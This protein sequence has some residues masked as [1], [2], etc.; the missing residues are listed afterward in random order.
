MGV[1][2]IVLA[3]AQVIANVDGRSN[4]KP[5]SQIFSIRSTT[6]IQARA[7]PLMEGWFK[8][9]LR[10]S[11]HAFGLIVKKVEVK[12]L[13]VNNPIKQNTIFKIID[14]V[15]VTIHYLTHSE[16][17]AQTG[18]VFGIRYICIRI[19]KQEALFIQKKL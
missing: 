4:R 6:W 9:N 18:Q 1:N 17:Y 10:C 19:A 5:I 15:A 7:N 14:R 13:A 8:N 12:W 3:I 2:L 11:K 16:G